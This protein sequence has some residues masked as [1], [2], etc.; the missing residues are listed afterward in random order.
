MSA[1]RAPGNGIFA[2]CRAAVA[3]RLTRAVRLQ[4]RREILP[5]PGPG[6][7]DETPPSPRYE[8]GGGPDGPW[9]HDIVFDGLTVSCV[10]RLP[11][12]QWPD[13]W[14]LRHHGLPWISCYSTHAG[15][16]SIYLAKVKVWG[17]LTARSWMNAGGRQR[18]GPAAKPAGRRTCAHRTV[19]RQA[20]S[21]FP[22]RPKGGNHG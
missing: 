19:P 21:G 3:S 2:A 10:D 5:P 6:P 12:D 7:A 18:P 20:A 4:G 1:S 13:Y 16:T 17:L 15:K 22:P 11:E 8:G 14:T 9:V